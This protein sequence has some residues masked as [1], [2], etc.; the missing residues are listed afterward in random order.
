M[1]A[2][3]LHPA[4]PPSHDDGAIM[5]RLAAG[6][7]SV[8]RDEL[9]N[10]YEQLIQSLGGFEGLSI[11]R[12]A[13]V[14]NLFSDAG[15]RTSRPYTLG[16]LR[17]IARAKADTEEFY[18]TLQQFL[19]QEIFFRGYALRCPHCQHYNWY[20]LNELSEDLRCRECHAVFQV[21]LEFTFSFKMNSVFAKG[22]NQGAL[23]VLL[24]LLHLYE[25]AGEMQW[26]P[27]Y[28]VSKDGNIIDLDLVALCDGM[29]IIA[30]CKSSHSQYKDV[31]GQL[32][33]IF[34]VAKDV[35]VDVFYY[36][37]LV[38]YVKKDLREFIEG[39]ALYTVIAT[40]DDLTDPDYFWA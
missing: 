30:E 17:S 25:N 40:R 5:E 2:R 38:K 16:E 22:L 27:G 24:T 8:K 18:S 37:T 7:Y 29:F 33:R 6:G 1:K 21:P 9:G 4:M 31:K 39:N 34:E 36:A 23:T 14:L 26:G 3:L 32:S 12:E 19:Q 10:L 35:N 13:H 20:E 28:L 11:L 15:I